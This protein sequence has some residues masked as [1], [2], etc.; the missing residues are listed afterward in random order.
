MTTYLVRRILQAIPLL[1]VIS[2]VLFAILQLLPEKPWDLL[3]RN[4]RM[5]AADRARLL[6]YYG[7]NQPFFVQYLTYMRNLLHFDLGFSYFSHQSTVSLIGERLPNTALLMGTS[8]IFTL[9]IAIPIGIITE[10]KQYS[11]L[12][13]LLTNAPSTGISR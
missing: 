11:K 3:L 6:A 8:Y 7:F 4:P 2:L 13:H 1:L 10:V 9:L 12:D 5:T